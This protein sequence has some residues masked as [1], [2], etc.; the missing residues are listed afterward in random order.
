MKS[1]F[2]SL[3]I[4]LLL[5]ACTNQPSSFSGDELEEVASAAPAE[6]P[7]ADMR[8]TRVLQSKFWVF[9]H[10]VKVDGGP[11]PE[12]KGRWYRFYEDGTYDGGQWDDHNDHGTYFLRE[13]N[14]WTELYVDSEINDLYDAKWQVQGIG[15]MEDAM[16][17]VKTKEFGDKEP[18]LC[19]LTGMLSM[20]TKEQWGM[21]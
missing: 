13:G 18:A 1:I 6:T 21:E 20:P 14:K 15:G 19:K 8:E 9:E 16:S 11:L 7:P 4:A 10:W 3:F 12:N 17:W 2:L 5:G